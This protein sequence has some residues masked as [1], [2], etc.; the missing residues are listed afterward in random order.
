VN[1]EIRVFQKLGRSDR[2][3]CIVLDGGYG[4]DAE[5][6]A[7]PPAIT[8]GGGTGAKSPLACDIRKDGR[9][10][11]LLKLI[12]G[13]VGVEYDEL[14]RRDIRRRRK[15]MAVGGVTAI[16]LVTGLALGLVVL[17][18]FRSSG[19]LM[20][21]LALNPWIF[22]F[23]PTPKSSDVLWRFSE[24]GYWVRQ[25]ALWRA[26]SDR[27]AARLLSRDPELIHASVG[28]NRE[29]RRELTDDVLGYCYSRPGLESEL[30]TAC[31]QEARELDAGSLRSMEYLL[32]IGFRNTILQA[33]IAL[34]TADE[35]SARL[36]AKD[37][38]RVFDSIIARI[39]KPRS[40]AF[41]DRNTIVM[42]SFI[43]AN[44]AGKLSREQAARGASAVR[45]LSGIRDIPE[46]QIGTCLVLASIPGAMNEAEAAQ[47][48]QETVDLIFAS[49][50]TTYQAEFEHRSMATIAATMNP[51]D[52]QA[53]FRRL[54]ALLPRAGDKTHVELVS[55]ILGPYPNDL[56][57][58][59]WRAYLMDVLRGRSSIEQLAAAALL[60]PP[61]PGA[62]CERDA[63]R[64]YN[65]LFDE[66]RRRKNRTV[67]GR[68][69]G[70]LIQALTTLAGK[71]NERDGTEA[72]YRALDQVTSYDDYPCAELFGAMR[73]SP[74]RNK[75][76]AKF[77]AFLADW[78]KHTFSGL[79]PLKPLATRLPPDIA[80]SA[81][82]RVLRFASTPGWQDSRAREMG[83]LIETL[84]ER[85][86]DEQKTRVRGRVI[87]LLEAFPFVPCTVLLPFE[88]KETVPLIVA[89]LKWPTCTENDRNRLIT[90]L[91]PIVG[92]SFTGENSRFRMPDAW[93]FMDWAEASG[94]DVKG[95]P[96]KRLPEPGKRQR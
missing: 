49:H 8:H 70:V 54:V 74:D 37:A 21:D 14:R 81:L 68:W 43:L 10:Q 83:D 66:L 86:T 47:R 11:A 41:P 93:K 85:L 33:P 44:L 78:E 76:E 30:Q 24:S 13:I 56:E 69:D 7:L 20:E 87:Q 22:R 17:D 29:T 92:Q 36:P 67:F 28:L 38:M 77:N 42:S 88:A 52:R 48:F 72:G 45:T 79:A 57:E 3:F 6:V 63:Y 25:N 31:I 58:G 19:A 50:Y 62:I 82:E 39:D 73:G 51:T 75:L 26:T 16:I 96:T 4:N 84:S 34:D 18:L 59:S 12:A 89:V 65:M 9:H 32:R 71:L 5:N 90:R 80:S 1:E 95:A 55:S 15:K 23:T 94:Y 64:T 2:I 35:M 53:Q 91:G 61:I 46:R 40:P 60:F 27:G